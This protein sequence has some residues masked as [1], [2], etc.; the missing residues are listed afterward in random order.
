MPSLSVIMPVHNG[1]RFLREAIDSILAQTFRDFELVVVDDGSTDE[2]PA[3]V[4]SYG[5][6]RIRLVRTATQSGVAAALNTG[7]RA[8]SADLIARQDADDVSEPA[9]LEKQMAAL[10]ARPQLALL[11]TQATIIDDA[12][13]VRGTVE[14]SVEPSSIAWCLLLDNAFVHTSVVFRRDAWESCG[15]YLERGKP[16]PEDYAL[17]CR[18]ARRFEVGNLPERLVRFRLSEA[19]TTGPLAFGTAKSAY[20][21]AF[22]GVLHEI[23][24]ENIAAMFGAEIGGDDAALL[25]R[26]GPGVERDE[27]PAL[28]AAFSRLLTAFERRHPA[29]TDTRDFARTLSRQYDAMAYR[30]TPPDRLASLA[31]YARGLSRRPALIAHLP[32]ARA[33]ALV[34]LGRAVRRRAH[35]L[36]ADGSRRAAG[37]P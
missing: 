32:W 33:L 12:G 21:S 2:S 13:R 5:D 23:V 29:E 6:P 26:F 17:W 8:A 34:T 18:I 25:A 14:R 15:A 3:I 11:G 7:I 16:F 28:C 4:A 31:V 36:R 37:A 27:A 30:V 10:R 20:A 1:A 9:R 19:S 35:T 22:A 24:T